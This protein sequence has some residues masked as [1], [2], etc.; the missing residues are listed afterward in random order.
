MTVAMAG[1]SHNLFGFISGQLGRGFIAIQ[2]PL[3]WAGNVHA[4][5]HMIQQRL[6]Q[7]RIRWSRGNNQLWGKFKFYFVLVASHDYRSVGLRREEKSIKVPERLRW[8]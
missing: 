7:L 2:N 5:T 6:E 3:V 8:E 4:I 1:L